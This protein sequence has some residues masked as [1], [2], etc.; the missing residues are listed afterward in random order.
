MAASK[1]LPVPPSPPSPDDP[2]ESPP[3]PAISASRSSESVARRAMADME[4]FAHLI[5]Q[6]VAAQPE[7]PAG[8]EMIFK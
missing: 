4:R 3:Q 8:P 2:P 1:G 6:G 7:R 5:S